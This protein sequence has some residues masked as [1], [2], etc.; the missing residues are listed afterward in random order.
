MR[1]L[2]IIIVVLALTQL[3]QHFAF[4]PD[5]GSPVDTQTLVSTGFIL[6]AAYAFGELFRRLR[7]P[8]LLGYLASGVV[9]GPSLAAL[10]YGPWS[11]PPLTETSLHQ[12]GL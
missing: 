5:S 11:G 1:Q 2:I 7:L 10:T 4:S 9:F 3:G 6:L 8:A 12:L